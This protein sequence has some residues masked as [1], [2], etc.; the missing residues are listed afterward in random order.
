MAKLTRYESTRF[1]ATLKLIYEYE[2]HFGEQGPAWNLAFEA[3]KELRTAAA[4][5]EFRSLTGP[6]GIGF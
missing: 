6:G 3:L 4:D 1:A 5:L 2:E